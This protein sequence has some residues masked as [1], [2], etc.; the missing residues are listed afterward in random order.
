M[1]AIGLRNKQV[2]ELF[3][4][5]APD[6]EVFTPANALKTYAKTTIY[7]G[8][9]LYTRHVIS[10][11]GAKR[12]LGRDVN[13]VTVNFGTNSE[14]MVRFITNYRVEGMWLQ[15]RRISLDVSNESTIVFR[16]RCGK[17]DDQ[18]GTIVAK[19]EIGGAQIPARKLVFQCPLIFKGKACLGA[20]AISEKSATYQAASRCNKSINQCVAYGNFE[21]FDAFRFVPITGN[22]SYTT[23]EVKR[24]SSFSRRR[25]R[26]PSARPGRQSRT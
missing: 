8:G 5:F 26:A 4:F 10:R 2:L 21:N 9:R 19:Q 25:K 17:P 13:A 24:F 20:Q 15:I 18:G 1:T 12:Y 14:E 23:T 11:S 22:F 7:W 3:E 16:G 6:E